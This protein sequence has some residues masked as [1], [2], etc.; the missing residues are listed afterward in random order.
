M[1]RLYEKAKQV[2]KMIMDRVVA[3]GKV[4]PN[5]EI[6]EVLSLTR[7]ELARILKD[8][9]A[10]IV[11]GLQNKA[12]AGLQ[13]FQEEKL[14]EP[15]PEVG[16]VF[17]ARPFASF[18]N[19][20]KIIVEGEQKW[21]GECAVEV[22]G[23]SSMFPGKEVMV[24]SVCRYT[25]DP[26]ELIG[27]DGVLR[28]YSPKTLRVH[29]G[30]PLRYMPDDAVGWCDYN[31][32]F[33]SEEA[34]EKWRIKHPNIKGITRDPETVANFV[35]LVAKG[36]L[37]YDYQFKFPLL[38]YLFQGRKYGFTKPLPGLG[39]HLPDPFW[40]PTLHTLLEARRKGYKPF[41]GVSLF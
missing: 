15:V 4:P 6:S 13:Y 12:H 7:E 22:C 25:K 18:K 9:E 34:V 29:F 8:L 24:R 31:S 30:I 27:R 11:V 28:D 5:A 2:R 41:I 21:A 39:L 23:I 20:Y 36:R 26:V 38:R 14:E 32:F 10:A 35:S 16:E 3:K 19:H 37:D 33:S 1:P 17:Y 40:M